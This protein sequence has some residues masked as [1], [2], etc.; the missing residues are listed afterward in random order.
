MTSHKNTRAGILQ[1]AIECV[2]ANRESDS[3]TPEDSFTRIA[4]YWT[5]HLGITVRA[6][7]V[8]IMMA[9]LKVARLG[10]TPESRDSWVDLAGYAACGGEIALGGI[11][12]THYEHY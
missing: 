4:E 10:T 7:D 12:E 11:T 6:T 5:T 1:I 2:T 9:L 3:G 8:A